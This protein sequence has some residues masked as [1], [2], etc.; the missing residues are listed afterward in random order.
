MGIDAVITWVDGNDQDYLKKK[1]IFLKGKRDQSKTEL[2]TGRD[3]TRFMDN[4]ELRYSV[5]SILKFAPWIDRI[6]IITD[7][8]R[9]HYFSETFMADHRISVI[10]HKVIFEGYEWALPTYNNRTIETAL[11]RVPGLSEKFIYFNDDFILTEKVE[12]SDF[13]KGD[14][15]VLR[16]EWKKMHRYGASRIFLNRLYSRLLRSFFG[17]TRSLHHL[18]QIRSAELAGMDE[19][20]FRFPHVP[21][22]L[23]RSTLE[24]YFSGFPK[25][26]EDNILYK[27]R[28]A[29]QFSSV[30]LAHYLEISAN[31]AD[32]NDTANVTMLNGELDGSF[33]LNKK[34]KKI[35]QGNCT[36]LSLQ[37]FENFSKSRRGRIRKVLDGIIFA[38][39]GEL[40]PSVRE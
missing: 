4:G 35:M 16:G 32:L 15:V 36:F 24:S 10:D 18:Q 8:Q 34:L 6:F 5:H 3:H 22:P 27:I 19:R 29:K 20:Y 40:N 9:P 13:F 25:Q 14:K 11:W 39:R 30:F 26:F 38:E 7:Q 37:G 12:P 33:F 1:G 17:I 21:H 28:D 2:V 23:R 31:N